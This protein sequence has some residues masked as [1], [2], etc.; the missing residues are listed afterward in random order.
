GLSIVRELV[1][2]HRGRIWYDSEVGNGT[3]FFVELPSRPDDSRNGSEH[4]L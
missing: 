1:M 2:V 3:T 4:D